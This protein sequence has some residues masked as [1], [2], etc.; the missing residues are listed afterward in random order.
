MWSHVDRPDLLFGSW[1]AADVNVSA[2]V[3]GF[4]WE[5]HKVAI[6]TR[7]LFTHST[8]DRLLAII[9]HSLP[10]YLLHISCY[11]QQRQIQSSKAVKHNLAIWLLWGKG[12]RNYLY[13]F[14]TSALAYKCTLRWSPPNIGVQSK[15]LFIPSVQCNANW[16]WWPRLLLLVVLWQFP[17]EMQVVVEMA[18]SCWLA[19]QHTWLADCYTTEDHYDH[20]TQRRISVGIIVGTLE[21]PRTEMRSCP[22]QICAP[23]NQ[24]AWLSGTL[25]YIEV[26][27]YK[28]TGVALLPWKL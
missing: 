19:F 4:P 3:A 21:T 24:M 12:G 15:Y 1:T 9:R 17:F 5:S 11:Q 10:W 14:Y 8:P 27:V 18:F 25:F 2:V 13:S 20:W 26:V 28:E 7:P 6:Q 23:S 22:F 16:N